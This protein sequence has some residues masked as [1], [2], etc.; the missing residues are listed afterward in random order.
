MQKISVLALF[1]ISFALVILSG[2]MN[3]TTIPGTGIVTDTPQITSTL[4]TVEVM[5]ATGTCQDPN[6]AYIE[7]TIKNTDSE[8]VEAVVVGSTYDTEGTII[9]SEYDI[10]TIEPNGTG[11]FR[12]IVVNGCGHGKWTY[13]ISIEEGV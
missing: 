12:I 1:L 11:S 2:C 5:T 6:D 4:S 9:G 13:A 8:P 10:V 3:T 7:G